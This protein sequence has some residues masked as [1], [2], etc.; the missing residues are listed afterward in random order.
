MKPFTVSTTLAFLA[1]AALASAATDFE[2]ATKCGKRFPRINQAIEI[3]CSKQK[4]RKLT[5]DLV[6]PSKYAD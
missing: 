1:F 3:F 5:N 4:D 2:N 6:V